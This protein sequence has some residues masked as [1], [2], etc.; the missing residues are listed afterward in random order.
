MLLVA[1]LVVAVLVVAAAPLCGSIYNIQVVAVAM[2]PHGNRVLLLL[3][4]PPAG[5][6]EAAARPLPFSCRLP[7]LRDDAGGHQEVPV[8]PVV[9]KNSR[10]CAI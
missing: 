8:V 1:P 2:Q 5:S 7:P 3:H 4:P 6:G 9:R 10:A